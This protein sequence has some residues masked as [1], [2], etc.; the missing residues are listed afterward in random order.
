MSPVGTAL[1]YLTRALADPLPKIVAV[2][3]F[4]IGTLTSRLGRGLRLTALALEL[5]GALGETL[6][7]FAPDRPEL[8]S[9]CE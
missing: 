4:V 7:G 3:L 5:F 2:R 6:R 9:I 1:C 8:L